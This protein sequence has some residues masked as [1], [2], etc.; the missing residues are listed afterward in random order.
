MVIFRTIMMANV[1]VEM[2]TTIA[3]GDVVSMRK[4]FLD[5]IAT[6]IWQYMNLNKF[7][8]YIPMY[9]SV[10]AIPSGPSTFPLGVDVVI[11]Q[12]DLLK[13]KL[14]LYTRDVPLLT[15]KAYDGMFKAIGE[16]LSSPP[17]IMFPL[18]PAVGS[19][20]IAFPNMASLGVPC[21]STMIGLGLTSLFPILPSPPLTGP[22]ALAPHFFEILSNF[23]YLGLFTNV[24]APIPT[25]LP[26]YA[27]TTTVPLWVFLDLP[28]LS[29]FDGSSAPD[30]QEIFDRFEVD[31]MDELM[32]GLK[33]PD[34]GEDEPK[35]VNECTVTFVDGVAV[36]P[37]TA[38][39]STIIESD[40]EDLQ[41][42][43]DEQD[44]LVED[45][46]F[47]DG[48]ENVEH[49]KYINNIKYILSNVIVETE[50]NYPESIDSD[51]DGLFKTVRLPK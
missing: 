4:S 50:N 43:Y 40:Y 27:G 15:P 25:T 14:D 46:T 26:P 23:I 31:D 16:W 32:D 33:S 22:V 17:M 45:D 51:K 48:S 47:D 12:L 41:D 6:S 1:S 3:S 36:I 10:G 7:L 8:L 5:G 9:V 44:G 13:S 37:T 2:L 24:P 28:D 29:I 30:M 20:Q 35:D 11:P 18:A 42:K 49:G 21:W 19:S 38:T 34:D 39:C